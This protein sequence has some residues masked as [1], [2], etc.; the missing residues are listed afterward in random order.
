MKKIHVLFS[1]FFFT[2]LTATTLLTIFIPDKKKSETENRELQQK[3]QLTVEN[4]STGK[5]QGDLGEYLSDQFPLREQMIKLNTLINNAFGNKNLNGAYKGENDYYF[6]VILDKN[7]DIDRY[8]SNINAINVFNQKYPEI[9]VNLMLV[10][11]SSDIY[12]DYLPKGA[13]IYNADILYEIANEKLDEGIFINIR[14][15]MES[16]K[17][18]YLYYKTDHHWTSKGAYLAYKEYCSVKGITPKSYD[19]FNFEDVSDD[20]YGSLHSKNLD[21][22]AKADIVSIAKNIGKCTV[23][24]N[25]IKIEMYDITKL[26]SKDKYLTFFGDNYAKTV[27][28]TECKNGKTLLVVK[29]SF[30]NSFVPLLTED[31]EK[32]IMI[33]QRY[34][35]KYFSS[36]IEE[37]NVTDTLFLYGVTNFSAQTKLATACKN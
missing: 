5:F 8:N 25:D 12:K 17:D 36:L 13:P 35:T 18:E 30:A 6:E 28:E 11:T 24:A 14:N 15:T 34:Y 16:N 32:I 9:K 1:I 23:M 7:I 4:V 2:L 19:E 3:P 10:P 21:A 37:Y 22:F 29:D 31:Y 26:S 33:D 20:F 27:I